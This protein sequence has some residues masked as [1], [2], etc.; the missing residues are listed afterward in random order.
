MTI[1]GSGRRVRTEEFSPG[2]AGYAPHGFGHHIDNI[3]D[4]P[5]RVLVAFD[6]GD[7][8]EISLST[9]LASNPTRL[10]ADNPKVLDAAVA[11]LPDHRV[12]VAPKNG[13]RH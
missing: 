1:F 4:T 5:C 7:Y 11:G 9:W 10:V 8:Q 3:G 2:D 6:K 12:Y 13:P